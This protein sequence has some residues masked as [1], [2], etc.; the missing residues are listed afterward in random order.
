MVECLQ[1]RTTS[2]TPP[3]G[4]D[5]AG[6][7]DDTSRPLESLAEITT[8]ASQMGLLRLFFSHHALAQ[9]LKDFAADE[10]VYHRIK[11]CRTVATSMAD[12]REYVT[13]RYGMPTLYIGPT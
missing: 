6:L 9:Q 2:P 10:I 5:S 7:F 3:G 12:N 11:S 1:P 4:L 8:L 13:T